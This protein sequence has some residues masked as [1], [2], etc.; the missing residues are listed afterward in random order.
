M[1]AR[2][3]EH[4]HVSGRPSR[5]KPP[6][7]KQQ[8]YLDFIRDYIALHRAPPAETDMVAFFRVSPPSVHRM[9]TTL[10]EKGFITKTA[11]QSRSIRLV[12]TKE[13][14]LQATSRPPDDITEALDPEIAPLVHALRA[15][16]LVI[17]K[18]SCWGHRRGAAFVELAVDG[19]AGLAHFVER[20][21]EVDRQVQKEAT[22]E[23]RLNW[24]REV[25]TSC[26][27]D[28]FPGW[29]MLSWRIRGSGR[30]DSP[31]AAL[32]K[33]IARLCGSAK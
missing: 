31:S 9:V 32:L 26:A 14:E 21:N 18:S 29:I 4:Q 6:T 12:A 11:G 25:V 28:L 8:A 30:G 3:G 23:V 20:L 15:D 5:A 1:A 16:P 33:K 10:A 27:F 24:S 2:L 7:P 13:T 22:F 19:P 17:T